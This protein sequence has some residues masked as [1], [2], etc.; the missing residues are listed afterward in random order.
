MWYN[1]DTV[2]GRTPKRV[3]GR[4]RKENTMDEEMTSSELFKEVVEENQTRKILE[5]LNE[6]KTLEE[7]KEKIRALLNK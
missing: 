6:C 3:R 7:A 4:C 5:I 2:E 1:I